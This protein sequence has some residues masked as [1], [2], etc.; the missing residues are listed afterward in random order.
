M[1][2]CPQCKERGQRK[3]AT[4]QAA[5]ELEDHGILPASTRKAKGM[6]DR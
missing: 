4:V 5:G 3:R 1:Q 6:T 2:Y